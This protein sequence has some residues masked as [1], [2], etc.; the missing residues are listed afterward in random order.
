MFFTGAVLVSQT[1]QIRT[2]ILKKYKARSATDQLRKEYI[3][4][5][6]N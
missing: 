2:E 6:Y 3:Q 1:K 4:S 5:A